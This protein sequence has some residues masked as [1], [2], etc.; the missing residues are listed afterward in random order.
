MSRECAWWG[1][2]KE[3]RIDSWEALTKELY[4]GSWRAP[5]KRHRLSTAF[6]GMS[7]EGDLTTSLMR[8]GPGFPRVEHAMLR[9]FRKYARLEVAEWTNI[10]YWLALAQH[11]GLPTRLLDFTYSPLVA[12]HFATAEHLGSPGVI[13]CVDYSQTNLL[14]PSRLRAVLA[15]EEANVFTAAMLSGVADS[16]EA[17]GRLGRRE[18]VAFFEPPSLDARIVN[19]FALFSLMSSPL[20]RLDEWLEQHP[21]TARRVIIPAKVKS[22]IRDMLDQANATERVFFPGLDG[23]SAYLRR[24]YAPAR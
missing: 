21:G 7:R 15:A 11:H 3:I 16:L 24:Y 2:V 12:M 14:L 22:R 8:M 9:A 1:W 17:L 4:A 18:F 19:Q 20:A 13:W 23:L 6:R 5:I 10:W